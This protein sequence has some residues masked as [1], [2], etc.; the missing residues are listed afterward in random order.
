MIEERQTAINENLEN[1]FVP[2][3]YIFTLYDNKANTYSAPFLAKTSQ[4]AKRILGDMVLSGNNLIAQ[5]PADYCLYQIG[6]FDRNLGSI[7]GTNSLY[8]VTAN[9][10]LPTPQ[11]TV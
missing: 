3:D 6:K 11:E 7:V 5:H 2:T 8:I 1:L 10:L 4:E 9:E